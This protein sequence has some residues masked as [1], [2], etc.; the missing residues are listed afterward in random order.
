MNTPTIAANTNA[1]NDPLP[2]ATSATG[3][4][5]KTD[6]AGVTPESV[7]KMLPRMPIERFNCWL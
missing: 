4:M 1:R 5:M 3:A 6:E 2:A 7:M